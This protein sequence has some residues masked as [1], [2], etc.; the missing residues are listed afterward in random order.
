MIA[1][2][3]P[4]HSLERHPGEPSYDYFS[5]W[6]EL[7]GCRLSWEL[8]FVSHAPLGK[9]VL[10]RPLGMLKVPAMIKVTLAKIDF[11]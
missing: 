9:Q 7:K 8:Q 1:G 6:L 10:W 11:K 4:K 3:G 5:R 2:N